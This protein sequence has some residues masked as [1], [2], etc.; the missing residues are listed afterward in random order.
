M[1]IAILSDLHLDICQWKNTEW[2]EAD[3]LVVAGDSFEARL[4]WAS[5]ESSNYALG[6][7]CWDF[8]NTISA[9]Y[10]DVIFICGNHEYYG[11]YF[12][13]VERFLKE[14][15][16]KTIH[17]L[18][19]DS[20]TIKGQMF[21][22]GTIWTDMGGPLD[23]LAIQQGMNDFR[24]ISTGQG[25]FTPHLAALIH[26]LAMKDIAGLPDGC[27]IVSHHAPSSKSVHPRYS[28]EGGFNKAYYSDWPNLERHKL[29]IHGHM[30]DPFDYY[31]GSC[32]VV[33]NPR[34]YYDDPLYK[35]K[36]IEI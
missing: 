35:I 29:V 21:Y 28:N 22:G 27:V 30:H 18:N 8:I 13:K 17:F 32:R 19:Q 3:V 4:L 15:L 20:V 10:S 5:P 11:S 2:P 7:E 26:G 16:P 12:S 6:L 33:C 23:R 24:K 31:V 9:R 14:S 1:K 34:G 36:V 25:K